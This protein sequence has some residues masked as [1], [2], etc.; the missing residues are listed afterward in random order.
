MKKLKNVN[1]GKSGGL[2]NIHPRL[3]KELAVTASIPLT[4]ICTR[5]LDTGTLP[6]IWKEATISAIFKK[7]DKKDPG[8]YRPVSLTCITCKNLESL[9]REEIITHMK[10]E[11]LF[12]TRQF[13]FVTGRSTAL[14]LL[15]V[16]EKWPSILD[17]GGNLDVIY[18]TWI[19]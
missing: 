12:S 13:G 11:K 4:A 1:A 15:H 17:N 7:G 9:I 5:T 2:D 16:M 10:E 3:L 6:A 18:C 8:N 14:Q 19:L